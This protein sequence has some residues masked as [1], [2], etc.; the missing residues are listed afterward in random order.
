LGW[1]SRKVGFAGISGRALAL[2]AR[3]CGINLMDLAGMTSGE[4]VAT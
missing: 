3:R 1:E 4:T 2:S